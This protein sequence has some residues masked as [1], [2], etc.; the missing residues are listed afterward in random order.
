MASRHVNRT[1]RPNTWL[2]RPS[3]RVDVQLV[4]AGDGLQITIC[5]ALG[6]HRHGQ[7]VRCAC[8][9]TTSAMQGIWPN[10]C[11]SGFYRWA[12]F[13][14]IASG[15]FRPKPKDSRPSHWSD[16]GSERTHIGSLDTSRRL[17]QAHHRQTASA[18]CTP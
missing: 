2:H 10:S 11:A 13:L 3:L 1:S 7:A 12:H 6:Q 15:H 17:M 14:T 16:G 8:A 4:S 18:L 9:E 5:C